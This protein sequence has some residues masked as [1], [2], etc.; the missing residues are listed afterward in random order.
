MREQLRSGNQERITKIRKSRKF[1]KSRE[2]ILHGNDLEIVGSKCSH[3]YTP[4]RRN[5]HL[6]RKNPNSS[7]IENLNFMFCDN[8][9][10][11]FELCKI[12]CFGN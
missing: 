5:G 4:Q 1:W 3:S 6:G 10:I 8:H 12:A 7:S 9:K 11:F 2:N